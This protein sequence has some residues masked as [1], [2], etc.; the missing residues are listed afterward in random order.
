MARGTTLL[1]LLKLLSLN[2]I[3]KNADNLWWGK[4]SP[5]A[6][7]LPTYGQSTSPL[8]INTPKPTPPTPKPTPHPTPKPTQRPT[9]PSGTVVMAGSGGSIQ[10]ASGN[11]WSITSGAQVAVNGIK[12]IS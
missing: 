7:W 4:T 2:F 10:D 6:Q 12:L 11:V 5:T 8:P 3:V 1:L 9:S